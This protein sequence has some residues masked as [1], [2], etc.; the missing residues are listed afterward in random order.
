M[1]VLCA[2]Q[3][4]QFRDASKRWGIDRG[5]HGDRLLLP[6]AFCLELRIHFI[7]DQPFGRPA[8]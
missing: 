6:S 2:L 5:E 7:L 3:S 1:T 4:E 8:S